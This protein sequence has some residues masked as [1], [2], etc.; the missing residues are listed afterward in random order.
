MWPPPSPIAVDEIR[1]VV[2]VAGGVGIKY[3][4]LLFRIS[5]L[6]GRG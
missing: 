5:D 1:K 3:V 4:V 2:F 6:R